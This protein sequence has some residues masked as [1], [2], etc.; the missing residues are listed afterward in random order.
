[1]VAMRLAARPNN[2]MMA[3]ELKHGIIGR[4]DLVLR[5]VFRGPIDHGAAPRN[6]SVRTVENVVRR[7]KKHLP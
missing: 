3:L 7:L 5:N 1:M 2:G 6:R 4:L